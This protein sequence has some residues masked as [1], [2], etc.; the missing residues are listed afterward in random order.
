MR[1]GLWVHAWRFL[2]GLL[3]DSHVSQGC[4]GVVQA[5][6]AVAPRGIY[7]CGNTSTSAGLTVTVVKDAVTGDHVFEAGAL[8]LAD[9]GACCIDEFEKMTS[10]HQA[11]PLS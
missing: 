10:E 1:R 2:V 3:V 5:A 4:S 11:S 7:V 8:V 9:R 6:A